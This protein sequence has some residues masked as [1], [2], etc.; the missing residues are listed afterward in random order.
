M[1]GVQEEGSM[2][3]RNPDMGW[4]LGHHQDTNGYERSELL[5]LFFGGDFPVKV[6]QLLVAQQLGFFGP[7]CS[8]QLAHISNKA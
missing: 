4:A 6:L 8:V 7:H 1:R 3:H 5:R 2:A